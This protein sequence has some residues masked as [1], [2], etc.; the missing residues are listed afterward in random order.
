MSI[1]LSPKLEA[2]VREKVQFGPY[3]DAEDVLHRALD[4]L[5]VQE[6]FERLR[7]S[8]EEA[9]A[10]IERGEGTE[11]SPELMDRIRKKADEQ[12]RLGIAPNPDV[13]P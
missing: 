10:E 5:E 12:I 2:I 11:W 7:A 6:R 3:E 8:I 4:L 1:T 13:C 9:D